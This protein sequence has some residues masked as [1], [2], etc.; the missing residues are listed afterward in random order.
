MGLVMEE[1]AA[2]TPSKYEE[3][4]GRVLAM[5]LPG[6]GEAREGRTLVVNIA[7]STGLAG[8]ELTK[9]V[10]RFRSGVYSA[11]KSGYPEGVR[12]S[13]DV[14]LK[15]SSSPEGTVGISKLPGYKAPVPRPPVVEA[16]KGA[17]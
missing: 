14:H 17:S 7:K 2:V 8:E 13:D 9:A 3:V 10:A 11:L 1:V 4:V 6:E 15:I 12:Q 5:A 16:L